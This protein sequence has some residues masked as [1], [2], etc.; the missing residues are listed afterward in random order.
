MDHPCTL[1]GGVR[2]LMCDCEVNA[3]GEDTGE[4][5]IVD[6]NKPLHALAFKIM[7]DNG[8]GTLD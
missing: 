3:E 2:G 5:A 1:C 8:S 4:F 7:D 6:P